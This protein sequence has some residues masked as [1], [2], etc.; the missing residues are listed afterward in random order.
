MPA[1]LPVLIE[2]VTDLRVRRR[3]I[4]LVDFRV[5][6]HPFADAATAHPRLTRTEPGNIGFEFVL[7]REEARLRNVK[8]RADPHRLPSH[9]LR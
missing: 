9:P 3:E 6:P 8:C 4:T 1:M 2:D 5:L 7:H